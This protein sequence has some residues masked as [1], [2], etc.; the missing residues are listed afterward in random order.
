VRAEFAA[1]HDQIKAN[2]AAEAEQKAAIRVNHN[3]TR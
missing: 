3:Q 1:R 2:Q